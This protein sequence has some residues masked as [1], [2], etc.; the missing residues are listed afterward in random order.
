MLTGTA[1]LGAGALLFLYALYLTVT[2]S[3]VGTLGRIVVLLVAA[4]A[5]AASAGG[6]TVATRGRAERSWLLYCTGVG[7]HV[8]WYTLALG[9]TR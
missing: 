2:G 3:V 8:V 7:L 5:V 4:G 6:L 1:F 9:L